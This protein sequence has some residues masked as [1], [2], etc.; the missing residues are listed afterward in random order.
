MQRSSALAWAASVMGCLALAQPA[1]AGVSYELVF[2]PGG[3][4]VASGSQYNFPSVA[5]A[6]AG[7]AVLDLW[8]ITSDALVLNSISVGFDNSRGLAADEALEW[9]G[10]QIAPFASYTPFAPGVTVGPSS[11][12]SFDGAAPLNSGPPSLSPGTYNIGTIVWDTS[13]AQAGT[14]WI[15]TFRDSRIDA[16]GA[17]LPAGSGNVV[18]ITG[19]EVLGTG[20]IHIVPEPGTAALLGLA[21]AGLAVASRR[22]APRRPHL[23]G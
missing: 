10:I 3:G 17:V 13:S 8:L 9:S 22:R 12:S 5:A 18:E 1:A 14:H 4:G 16:T 23:L 11:L 15:D 2:R 20:F 7:T 6:N 19:T 21:L